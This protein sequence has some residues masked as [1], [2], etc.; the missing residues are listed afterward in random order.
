MATSNS[1]YSRPQASNYNST[2]ANNYGKTNNNYNKSKGNN[3]NKT[4][5]NN[6]SKQ[7]GGNYSKQ[8]GNNYNK[9][10]AYDDVKRGSNVRSDTKSNVDTDVF[11]E[12]QE[13]QKRLD[14]EKKIKR[15]KDEGQAIA[16]K[17]KKSQAR[18]K[19][20]K[21]IDWTK[22]YEDGLFDDDEYYDDYMR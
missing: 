1:N 12:K 6:Y 10:G 4:R 22:G 7:Q 3:Y 20:L 17:Q 21:N 16:V 2:K 8:Q 9:H 11:F 13:A 18:P 14:R 15:R 19:K 5:S